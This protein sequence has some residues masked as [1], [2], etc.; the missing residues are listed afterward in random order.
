MRQ[1]ALGIILATGTLC[2]LFVLLHGAA[3]GSGKHGAE[4]IIGTDFALSGNMARY[5]TWA[6]NGAALAA[7]ELN[8]QGGVQ[9]HQLRLSYED[10]KGETALAV[11]AYQKLRSLT[12]TKYVLTFL[13]SV[14]LA[15]SPLANK[16]RVIQ[17]DVSATTPRY[18]TPDDY[19]FRTA[20]SASGLAAYAAEAIFTQ[21]QITRLGVLYIEAEFGQGMADAFCAHYRGEIALRDSFPREGTDFRVQLLKVKKAGVDNVWFV[22]HL[23]ESGILLR[24]AKELGLKVQ[25]F[26]D[27][28]SVEG[29]EFLET[30]KDAANGVIYFSV[31]FDAANRD[32]AVAAFV[33]HYRERFG[34]TPTY[35]AAQAYDGVYAL[36]RGLNSCPLQDTNCVRQSLNTVSFAGASGQI[37]FDRFGD[38]KKEFSIKM[39]KNKQFV[40]Y[41]GD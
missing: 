26:T 19:T 17:M 41:S 40:P 6:A 20:V 5:G 18:S 14:A 21:L 11:A 34:E 35:F 4:L 12:K 3:A 27:M 23:Y 2:S 13:S 10:N 38:V 39:V 8:E 36:A 25:F 7:D 22:G 33:R 37:T 1:A 29:P 28:Y 30:A 32:P 24:Q 9:G 16:D 31:S 15:V